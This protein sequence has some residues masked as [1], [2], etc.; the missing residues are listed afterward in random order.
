VA[1]FGIDSLVT[2]YHWQRGRGCIPVLK[3]REK[4]C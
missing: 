1:N 3:N 4:F 2:L